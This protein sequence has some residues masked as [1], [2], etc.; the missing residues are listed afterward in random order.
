MKDLHHHKAA[1]KFELYKTAFWTKN[2][3]HTRKI[4]C[5]LFVLYLRT[6]QRF[7]ADFP[8]DP[9]RNQATAGMVGKA[10]T[11]HSRNC[12]ELLGCS[13]PFSGPETSEGRN[14]ESKVANSFARFIPILKA[15]CLLDFLGWPFAT[16]K[17]M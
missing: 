15:M 4:P 12:S 16:R 10:A 9:F 7:F 1:Q 14:E 5:F 6:F 11:A 8:S 3:P 2:Q 17:F 13:A